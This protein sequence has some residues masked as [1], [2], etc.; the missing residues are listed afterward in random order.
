ML[1]AL[2][3]ALTVR[4]VGTLADIRNEEMQHAISR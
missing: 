2:A 1:V 4:K 3:A